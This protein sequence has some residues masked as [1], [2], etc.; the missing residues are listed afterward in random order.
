MSLTQALSTALSGLQVNQASISIV[1]ANVANAD[2]PGY[3]RKVVTQVAIGGSA[4]IGVRVSDIRREIDLYIQRQLRVENAG[5]SYAD[6]RANM[7]SQLQDI[8]GLTTALTRKRWRWGTNAARRQI[9]P[10][11]LPCINHTGS[12][13]RYSGTDLSGGI[14]RNAHL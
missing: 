7:Y 12:G 9:L 8:Y 1:A 5:A 11:S 14:N 10:T 13:S 4:S 2:T 3:T 6:T